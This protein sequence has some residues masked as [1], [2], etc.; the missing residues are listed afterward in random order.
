M[1]VVVPDR[2]HVVPGG[3]V[4]LWTGD[5]PLASAATR[6]RWR[7]SRGGIARSQHV[8]AGPRH[9]LS[10]SRRVSVDQLRQQTWFAAPID[11]AA[12]KAIDELFGI[13]KP[14]LAP[15]QIACRI[16]ENMLA[17]LTSTH[18]VTLLPFSVPV[19]TTPHESGVARVVEAVTT[20]I[21][22]KNALIASL[23]FTVAMFGGIMTAS[24][25]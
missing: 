20:V 5:R 1:A 6:P 2:Y 4:A 24:V 10:G 25:A 18:Q 19:A 13:D 11:S 16:P 23:P 8:V 17:M 12:I 3:F 21:V 9:P 7:P 15:F 14:L 22:V